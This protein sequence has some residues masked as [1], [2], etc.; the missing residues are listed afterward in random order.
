MI[1][2]KFLLFLPMILSLTC[3]GNSSPDWITVHIWDNGEQVDSV[4][5]QENSTNNINMSGRRKTIVDGVVVSD[6]KMYT[7]PYSIIDGFYGEDGVKYFDS[8]GK[9]LISSWTKKMPTDVYTRYNS[10]DNYN[11]FTYTNYGEPRYFDSVSFVIPDL[12]IDICK[13][14]PNAYLKFD[15]TFDG[16]CNSLGGADINFYVY[17]RSDSAQEQFFRGVETFTYDYSN[18]HVLFKVGTRAAYYGK[19]YIRFSKNIYVKNELLKIS[20]SLTAD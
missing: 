7:S 6:T 15:L 14:S 1:M 2:K 5:I 19:V 3:C 4:Y 17:D 18:H 9:C 10:F 20:Y 11:F 13:I 8:K 16:K 12:D